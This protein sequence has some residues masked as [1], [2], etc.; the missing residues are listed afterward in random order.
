[1][2]RCPVK[3]QC[4]SG[5]RRGASHVFRSGGCGVTGPPVEEV[6]PTVVFEAAFDGKQGVGT[7]LR[8]VAP[9][10]FES[11]ADDLLA[12]AFHN[13]GSDW[14]SAF[15]IVVV[16]LMH[17][18]DLTKTARRTSGKSVPLLGERA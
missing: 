3:N 11:A 8:P 15:P 18:T 4:G 7:R 9:A 2:L 10:S 16:A 6:G 12:S 14:Q 13:T 17:N 5:I 1:M